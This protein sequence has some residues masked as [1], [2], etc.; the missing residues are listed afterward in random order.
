MSY[1]LLSYADSPSQLATLYSDSEA[2]ILDAVKAY[3]CTILA[4]SPTLTS[5]HIQVGSRSRAK[6][7][8]DIAND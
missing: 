8:F 2:P 7:F 4:K 3:L 6:E 1:A 5:S